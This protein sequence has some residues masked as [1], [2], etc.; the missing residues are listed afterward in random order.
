MRFNR[1]RWNTRIFEEYPPNATQTER[2]EASLVCKAIGIQGRIHGITDSDIR[3][4]RGEVNFEIEGNVVSTPLRRWTRY[5]IE[6]V[7]GVGLLPLPPK[8]IQATM[9]EVEERILVGHQF[10]FEGMKREGKL[11][12]ASRVRVRHLPSDHSMTAAMNSRQPVDDEAER[13][14]RL[15]AEYVLHARNRV[16]ASH[17]LV[18]ATH[19]T[20]GCIH[21][22]RTEVYDPV[23]EG[24]ILNT[25]L[26]DLRGLLAGEREYTGLVGGIGG[27]RVRS[28]DP[29]ASEP[30]DGVE[31]GRI[32]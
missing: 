18:N 27:E 9:V 13:F 1:L 31:N 23:P 16:R 11:A 15:R 7:G 17:E 4:Q 28:F 32:Q 12:S 19:K 22:S 20:V 5:R 26:P 25:P 24:S 2:G 6:S 29:V 3:T 14:E 21:P 10:F 8:A 30:S